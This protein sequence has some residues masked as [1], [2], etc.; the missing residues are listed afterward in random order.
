MTIPR[1]PG[2]LDFLTQGFGAGINAYDQQRA[3]QYTQAQEGARDLINLILQGR[4]DPMALND[5][6]VQQTLTAAK[7]PVP[8][9]EN[10]IPSVPAARARRETARIGAAPPGSTE[11]SLILNLPTAGQISEADFLAQAAQIRKEVMEKYPEV[12]RKLAGVFAPE[13]TANQER[14]ATASAAPKEYDF[15]AENFVAQAGLALSKTGPIKDFAQLAANAKALAAADP[16]YADLVKNGQ[17]SDEYFARAARGWQRLSEEDRIKYADIAA[18]RLAAEREA[19][20]YFGAQD[21]SYDQDIQR[22]QGIIKENTPGEFDQIFLTGIQEKIRKGQPLDASEQA[23]VDKIQKRQAA[24][25]EIQRLQ[26]ERSDLRDRFI[27]DRSPVI[28]GQEVV[29]PSGAAATARRPGPAAPQGTRN[30]VP[31][32]KAGEGDADYWE[33]LKAAG[34]PPDQA[35]R[36]VRGAKP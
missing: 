21:K 25:A 34:I 14:A 30:A 33:R 5:P 31:P 11:E 3:L 36:I 20:Y 1:L 26:G 15:A 6:G 8:S 28:P 23:I 9:S 32:R 19:R 18:K 4:V 24:E 16:Q 27:Q 22:L 2:P 13:A 7:I 17:L 35:T 12:G 29:P 10:I